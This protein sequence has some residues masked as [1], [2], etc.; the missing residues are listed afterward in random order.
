MINQTLNN[1]GVLLF[2]FGTILVG[3][4]KE[5]CVRA[6]EQIGC[7]RIAYYVD[8][9]RQEDLFHD[10]EIGGSIEAFCD[11]ARRQS[12]Y[13]DEKG[14]FHPCKATNDEIC[15]A[16]NQLLLDIPVEKLRLIYHLHHD[17]GVHTAV[18]SNTNQIHWQYAVEHL[19]TADGLTVNDY[20]DEIF[21]SCDMQM[22]KP[23][24]CIYQE[25]LR[26][27]REDYDMPA[28]Q[29]HDIL[30]IDDS[31]KN[32]MAA[33]A[34]GI[35][36]LH[37]PKGDKWNRPT[38]LFDLPA[39][40]Y[41]FSALSKGGVVAC[42]GNFDGVHLGHLHVIEM[43]KK[44]VA[45]RDLRPMVITFDRHPRALFDPNFKPEYISTPLEKERLL[46]ATGVDV[47]VMPFV[48]T[49]ADTTAREFMC[50]LRDDMGV[51]SLLLGYDNRF[52]KRNEYETFDTYVE[53]GKELGIEVVRADAVDVSGSRVSSSFVR[54]LV[55]EGRVEE[56]SQCLGYAFS[57]TSIVTEGHQ[58]GRKIG[59]PTANISAPYGKIVPSNGVYA[60]ET[61]ID[62]S[63]YP[64]V[65]NIGTRPTYDDDGHRSI[66]TH[67]IGFDGD[68]YGRSITVGFCR[69]LRDERQFASPEELRKQI[70]ADVSQV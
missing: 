34:N 48:Q 54:R 3:L 44:I 58:E 47:K 36:T 1:N 23:D 27:L 64:S 65:T 26:K 29:P 57:I 10:L 49:L 40:H 39:S 50:R 35:R 63:S 14:T 16:W 68:L 11:E 56:A 21:L 53:Y 19:F 2:D 28:L 8:E 20:F 5:R 6:L 25:M 37:D 62:G 12:S 55:R 18:L 13:T 66:E 43:L 9:C 52:G 61:T 30:F 38:A 4:S 46:R 42:I 22:V 33:E 70:A 41:D 15:W 59:F 32:C 45:E 7:G 24:D 51:K 67:V 60:T 17:L 31:E 69:R